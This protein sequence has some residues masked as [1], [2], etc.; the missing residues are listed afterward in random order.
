MKKYQKNYKAGIAFLALIILVAIVAA[1]GVGVNYASK[2]KAKVNVEMNATTTAST[3]ATGE[4]SLRDL[5]GKNKMCTF[6]SMGENNTETKGTAYINGVNL[7]VDAVTTQGDKLVTE[8]H[9][10]KVGAN[11]YAW[12]S[13]G[14]GAGQGA[15]L[16]VDANM[17]VESNS[18]TAVDWDKKSNYDCTDWN[19]DQG[20]F[21][22][23]T[24]IT[25]IDVSSMMQA[26]SSVDI[27]A[28]LKNLGY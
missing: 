13:M 6:S 20:K 17:Q 8:S 10:I 22:V 24:D 26:T 19:P 4:L 1:A 9:M 16:K 3:T 27:N 11:V 5:F 25:F 23:P 18:K 12:S 14:A 2:K 7:R 21:T 28:K 15:K